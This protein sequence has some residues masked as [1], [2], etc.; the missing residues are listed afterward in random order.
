MKKLVTGAVAAIILGFATSS[1]AQDAQPHG[2]S[3][4][5]RP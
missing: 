4:V 2:Y 5:S 3:R 1:Q